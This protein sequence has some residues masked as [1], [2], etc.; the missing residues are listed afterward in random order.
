MTKHHN[1]SRIWAAASLA[2]AV[3]ATGALAEVRT[4][5]G[6]A[7]ASADAIETSTAESNQKL[8]VMEQMQKEI[9]AALGAAGNAG[10]MSDAL[11]GAV[12]PGSGFYT[13][14]QQFGYDM[15]AVT[16]CKGNDPVGTK[17]IEEARTWAMRNLYTQG[18]G[19]GRALNDVALRDL[20]EIRRRAMAYS[21]SNALALSVTIHNDLAGADGMASALDAEIS[22]AGDMRADIQANSAVLLALYKVSLQQLAVATAQL[23]VMASHS[24]ATTTPYHEEGGTEFADAFIDTDFESDFA[25]RKTV[26]R[27]AQGSGA[28]GL[29]R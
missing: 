12:G 10:G 5:D 27:P 17:D 24:I 19:E 29:N 3:S 21:A 14:M 4:A 9:A 8:S 18:D 16:L 1:T 15:C 22:A 23:D 6:A 26:T 11:T 13:N 20:F 7:R 28:L 2:L 25:T